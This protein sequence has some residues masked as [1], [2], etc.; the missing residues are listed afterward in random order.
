MAEETGDQGG[1]VPTGASAPSGDSVP[2]AVH[3]LAAMFGRDAAAVDATGQL[4]AAHLAGLAGAGLYGIFA[5]PSAGG[6]GLDHA[7][8]CAVVE[9]LAAGCLATTFVWIQ[10]FRLLGSLLDPATPEPLRTSLL[11]RVVRGEVRGGVVLAGLLPGPPQLTARPVPGGWQLDGQAPWAT[12]W[13]HAGLLAVLARGPDDSVVTL[14][15]DAA[16]QPGLTV[17]RLRL[18]AADASATVRLTFSG[19]HVP[20]DR[21]VGQRPY[22]PVRDQAEGLRLNGSLPLGVARRCCTLI[23]PSPL[24]VELGHARAALD[25][26]STATMPAARAGAAEFAVRAA[27]AL[28]VRRGSSSAL[29]GDEADR[30]TR[31]AAF[32]LVFGSRPAIKEALLAKLTA[33]RPS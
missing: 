9:E 16:G 13:G 20:A 6:L 14:L 1:A 19:L 26:A 25:A 31:E 15:L 2:P 10:H 12:G 27:H 3:E 8:A 22:D 21:Y 30:L 23:G 33:A 5:P 24:D 32:L 29:A 17:R 7:Q 11:P 4:P 28:A 18:A